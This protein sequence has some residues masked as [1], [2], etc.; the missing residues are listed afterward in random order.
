MQPFIALTKSTRR[1]SG[2]SS[3]HILV[4]TMG[5]PS[6]LSTVA[7]NPRVGRRQYLVTY[8]QA[9]E[10]KFSTRESFG[11]ML[12]AEF[13]AGTSVVKVDY[14]ACQRGAPE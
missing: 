2:I 14:W 12:E 13:N 1:A 6:N 4:I 10:S 8:S 7:M 9:D 11:K 5:E 3:N